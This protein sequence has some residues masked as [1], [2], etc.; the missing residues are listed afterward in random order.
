VACLRVSGNT[1]V[2]G[3]NWVNAGAPAAFFQVVDAPVD[4]V[5]LSIELQVLGPG[6]CPPEVTS[7]PLTVTSGDIVVVDA[8]P[9]PTSKEQCA[10][11]GW[12]SFPGFENQGDCV[13]YV[14]TGGKN[15]PG[16]P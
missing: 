11:G 14:A 1:A 16:G 10:N 4:T 8:Q 3:V 6:D 15:Q 12:Q 7:N 5:N 13:S 9:F 2:I